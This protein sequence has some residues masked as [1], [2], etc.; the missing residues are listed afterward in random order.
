MGALA[1]VLVLGRRKDFAPSIM[2]PHSIPLAVLGS[3][4][5][6]L[7]WFGFNAGSELASGG[8]AGN[9]VINTHMASAVSALIWVGFLDENW[10]TECNCSN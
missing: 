2:V 8:V 9:T 4:L 6:W 10:K 5:L 3:S 1:A 7:G